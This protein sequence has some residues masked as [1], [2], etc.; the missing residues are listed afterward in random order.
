MDLEHEFD[1]AM[2]GTYETARANGYIATYF[3]QMIEQYGG[4]E[5]ARRLLA[6]PGPQS[7]LYRLWEL[8]LLSDS[9]E[10]LVC[11]KQFKPLFSDD[12]IDIARAR[13]VELGFLYE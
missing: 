1:L 5:T 9:M 13:L 4:V 11:Q 3:L 7:G 8:E 12:E 10:A 2:R 6:A